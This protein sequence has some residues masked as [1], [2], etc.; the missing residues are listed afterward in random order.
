MD[1]EKELKNWE[2]RL[3]LVKELLHK[4]HLS[5]QLLDELRFLCEYRC[6]MARMKYDVEYA[7][8]LILRGDVLPHHV[9]QRCHG[10]TRWED[11]QPSDVVGI[12]DKEGKHLFFVSPIKPHSKM[13]QIP[14]SNR[15]GPAIKKHDFNPPEVNLP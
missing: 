11:S 4:N 10:H 8:G 1:F 7:Q 9:N 15:K 5:R 13:R 12:V 6:E 14:M 3:P 2:N